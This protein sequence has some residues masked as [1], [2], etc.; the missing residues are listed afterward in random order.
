MVNKNLHIAETLIRTNYSIWLVWTGGVGVAVLLASL[1]LIRILKNHHKK[2]QQAKNYEAVKAG[3]YK[4]QLSAF[5]YVV[6]LFSFAALLILYGNLRTH[7]IA[8]TK[9]SIFL[10]VVWSLLGGATTLVVELAVLI[11]Y[12]IYF[13]QIRTKII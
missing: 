3:I 9:G 5:A 13:P 2:F 12:V 7:I 10:G 6:C 1:R 11:K 8:N 4:I